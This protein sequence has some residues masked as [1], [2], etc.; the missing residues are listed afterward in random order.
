M[1]IALDTPCLAKPEPLARR[2]NRLPA[3]LDAR[4]I[5]V[6]N[7][8]VEPGIDQASQPIPAIPAA[9]RAPRSD[10]VWNELFGSRGHW[11]KPEAIRTDSDA[12]CGCQEAAPRIHYHCK[13]VTS[14]DGLLASLAHRP[15]TDWRDER[16]LVA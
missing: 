4:R 10:A 1:G 5:A 12:V 11:L 9:V 16:A 2:A 15:R 3:V 13:A 6:R 14:P 8:P 7:A